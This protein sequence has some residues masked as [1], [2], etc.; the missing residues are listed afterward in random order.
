MTLSWWH[1]GVQRS[2]SWALTGC[3][4]PQGPGGHSCPFHR[5][6]Q[7]HQKRWQKCST[8]LPQSAEI[9]RK[10][11]L[12]CICAQWKTAGWLS[13]SMYCHQVSM[14]QNTM[15][16]HIVPH[17]DFITVYT[18]FYLTHFSNTLCWFW[19]IRQNIMNTFCWLVLY[20][21]LYKY[22]LTVTHYLCGVIYCS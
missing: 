17:H 16:Q 19:Y 10:V 21:L 7:S 8:G 14:L 11:S 9:W 6:A 22:F 12:L 13:I 1:G 18:P 15:S 3:W 2:A 5:P 20:Q 4:S